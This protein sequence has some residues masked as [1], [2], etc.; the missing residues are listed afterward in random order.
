MKLSSFLTL[1][2]SSAVLASDSAPTSRGPKCPQKEG[3]KD[4]QTISSWKEQGLCFR[5]LGAGNFDK[6]IAPCAG[7][8]GYCQ[9]VNKSES[10]VEG[11]KAFPNQPE[12]DKLDPSTILKDEDCNEFIPGQCM[13]ECGLC[14]EI[15]KVIIEGLEQLDNVICAV[16]LSAFKTIADVG[17]MF[18]PGGQ[19]SSGV[20]A[21]VQG[22]K[23]FYENGEDAASFFGNWIGPACGVPDFDF[24]LS[25]VF[26]PLV[27]APDSM[28][29]GKTVGCKKKSGC[30]KVD[31]VPDPEPKTKPTV[32]PRGKP[33]HKPTRKPTIKSTDKPKTT[34]QKSTVKP[35]DKPETTTQK[36]T[37][38]PS[39]K[40]KTTTQ[41][42][43]V[44]SSDKPTTIE[45]PT[46]TTA[47]TRASSIASSSSTPGAGCAYCG[48]FENKAARDDKY[49]NM[50]A[51]AA[52]GNKNN[53][54][55]CAIPPKEDYITKKDLSGTFL[56]WL[57]PRAFSL[58]ERALS[59][60]K[61]ETVLYGI[62]WDLIVG[63]YAPSSEAVNIPDITKYWAFENPGN[64]QKCSVEVVKTNTGNIAEFET[65]HVYEAQTLSRFVNWLMD[66]KNPNVGKTKTYTKPKMSWVKEVLVD[67]EAPN[68]FN[69]IKPGDKNVGD[70]NTPSD[71]EN[72]ITLMAYGFG[73]SDGVNTYS[74]T[75]KKWIERIPAARG[76]KNLVLLHKLINKPKG[77]YFQK[78]YLHPDCPMDKDQAH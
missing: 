78:N 52:S 64:S 1:L 72:T 51:R 53:A 66:E 75:K 39:D 22:A 29:R 47:T 3:Y 5:Y 24:D 50:Y 16:M 71:G 59:E 54:P 35:T 18:V 14:D 65:D 25:M 61:V 69:I 43:T 58:N 46:S 34:A 6:A 48:E 15:S 11:C 36:P 7:P 37:V 38:K 23:S 68:P 4:A 56:D 19:A 13:C 77:Q 44:K 67:K 62:T 55:S 57:I 21:A 73:R 27:E 41:K 9:K 8:D 26:N 60:K 10:G 28:S 76:N 31:P 42:P 2:C 32:E 30:R 70:L 33:K 45:K 63:N 40:P 74:Q 12:I 17:L 49:R 20:K